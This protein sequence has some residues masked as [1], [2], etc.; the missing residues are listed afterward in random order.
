MRVTGT[1]AN[2]A[3]PTITESGTGR[4]EVPADGAATLLGG[5]SS[6]GGTRAD[7]NVVNLPADHTVSYAYNGDRIARVRSAAVH[8]PGALLVGGLVAPPVLS[9]RRRRE[10]GR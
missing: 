1:I 4:L 5:Y 9:R 3:G 2:A 10:A 6:L 8:D 7:A